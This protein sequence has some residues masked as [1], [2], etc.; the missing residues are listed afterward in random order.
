MKTAW[1]PENVRA[2]RFWSENKPVLYVSGLPRNGSD[3]AYTDK[4]NGVICNGLICDKA[5]ELSPYWQRKFAA[6]CRRVGAEPRFVG[7][8][9]A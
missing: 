4:P 7:R 1:T 6:D 3:W 2:W 8:G 9:V 5:I